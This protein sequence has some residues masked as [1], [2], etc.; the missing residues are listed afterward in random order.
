MSC[1]H[2]HRYL[3]ANGSE[4]SVDLTMKRLRLAACRWRPQFHAASCL[5]WGCCRAGRREFRDDGPVL[6]GSNR[7]GTRSRRGFPKAKLDLHGWH[8]ADERRRGCRP[9]RFLRAGGRRDPQCAAGAPTTDRLNRHRGTVSLESGSAAPCW[10]DFAGYAVGFFT[11]LARTLAS[12][13]SQSSRISG[14]SDSQYA[15]AS[16]TAASGNPNACAISSGVL[17][18]SSLTTMPYRIRAMIRVPFT[19][20]CR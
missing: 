20:I 17:G 4:R 9:A 15:I 14:G 8:I 12:S 3:I 6:Q 18:S 1:T 7:V 13:R 2:A 5:A 10:S 16:C 19:N 11:A